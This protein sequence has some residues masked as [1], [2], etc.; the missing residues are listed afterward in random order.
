MLA[1]MAIGVETAQLA[2]RRAAWEVRNI[3]LFVF[4]FYFLIERKTSKKNKKNQN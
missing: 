2:W 4:V 3:L 1:D